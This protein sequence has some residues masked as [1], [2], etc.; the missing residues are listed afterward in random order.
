M[1]YALRATA[2]ALMFLL[3]LAAQ[4]TRLKMEGAQING[5]DSPAEAA[6]WLADARHWR[7]ERRLRIGFGDS[8]YRRPELAWTQRAFIQ[9]QMMV[10][11]RYFYDPATRRYTVDRY[12]DDLEKRYG[13]IDAVLIWHTY[14]NIGIDDCNQFDHFRDLPGGMEGVRGMIDAFHRRGV[15]VLFPVM[16]WDQGTRDAGE[17]YWTALARELAEAGADGVNGDTLEAVPRSM[18]AA[19]D[20]TGRPLAFEPEFLRID[21]ALGWNNM[22][23]GSLA[24]AFVPAVSRHK[25]LEPRH[26]MNICRRWDRDKTDSLQHAWFNGT[27]YESW[28]NVWGIWNQIPER[29]AEALRRVAKLERRF[30]DL[31]VGAE[32]EP[33]A[34]T[35][36]YGVFAS[37]FPSPARTL[38]T[39]VNRNEFA[40]AGRQLEV[41][42]SAGL[43]YYDLWHGV[44]LT[45]EVQDGK[46]VLSFE[47]EGRGFGGVLAVQGTAE[48]WGPLL[49]EMHELARVK[50][51]SLEARR[52]FLPQQMTP[53]AGTR[54]AGQAPDGMVR[55]PGARSWVFEVRGVEIEGGNQIG[56]DV[57]YPWEDSPRRYHRHAME[58]RPFYIDRTP[59]TNA[60]F[61]RFLDAAG[62][63]PADDHNFLRHWSGGNFPPGAGG[64]P[65][66]WVSIEDARAYAAWAGKRLPHEWEWQYAAQGAGQR[67]YPWGD[68]WDADAVPEPCRSRTMRVPGSVGGHPKGTSVFGVEDT[69]GLVW[70]WT[71][72]FRDEHTRAAILRGG[73]YYQPQGSRWYFPQAYKLTEHGKLLLM[74]PGKDRSGAIGFRCVMDGD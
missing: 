56:V 15:R 29:D 10:E 13:G 22:S 63:H 3:N 52:P 41:A 12:L 30:A 17:S 37:R 2:V 16:P 50:L 40:V 59:V 69:T 53:I 31:L 67:L 48:E 33:Y 70:Q 28:E 64:Q 60:E 49:A 51:S 57:Q 24:S 65:V 8:E 9:P 39:I 34:P 21:E 61:K 20:A 73:S 62:Y 7:M 72:E 47:M 58:I 55:I 45:P 74:A 1:G 26:M 25:W 54:R 4:D 32:W 5:P 66:R 11:D 18:R 35:L 36:Q 14:P 23:W 44:E 6:A 71:S 46:A 68:S 42:H 43:H 38:Y 19:S 27:G